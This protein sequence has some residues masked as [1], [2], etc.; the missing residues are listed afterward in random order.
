[1][2]QQ[3]YEGPEGGHS[4]QSEG[5]EIQAGFTEVANTGAEGRAEAT[6][7]STEDI[8]ETKVKNNETALLGELQTM[9]FNKVGV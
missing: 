6:E 1:M 9:V 5:R 2:T 8:Q 4:A 7:K 3:E